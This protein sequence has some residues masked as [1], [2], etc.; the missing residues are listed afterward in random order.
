MSRL[1]L[2]LLLACTALGDVTIELPPNVYPM[3]LAV[4][5]DGTV[6]YAG[7][8]SEIGRVL[9]NGQLERLEGSTYVIGPMLALSDGAMVV[10]TW[11]GITRVD[12][13]MN[14]S[15]IDLSQTHTRVVDMVL[16]ADGAVWFIAAGEGPSFLGRI[17]ADGTIARFPL[18]IRP[19]AMAL[20]PDGSFTIVDDRGIIHRTTPNGAVELIG[21]FGYC[22]TN[23][24]KVTPDGTVWFEC[25][26]LKP[27][28]G[29]IGQ[30]S[31]SYASTIGPDGKV[32]IAPLTNSIR[33]LHDDGSFREVP[34]EHP[35]EIPRSIASSDHAIWYGLRGAIRRFDP[36]TPIDSRLRTGDIVSIE[37]ERNCCWEGEHPV[38]AFHHRGTRPFVRRIGDELPE[39]GGIYAFSGERILFERT[40][41]TWGNVDTPLAIILDG[42]GLPHESIAGRPDTRGT[43]LVVDRYGAIHLL[44]HA[45]SGPGDWLVTTDAG[46]APLRDVPVPINTDLLGGIDLAGD[47]CTLFYAVS[48]GSPGQVGRFDLCTGGQLS[49]FLTGLPENPQDLRILP[50]GGLVVVF[51]TRLVRYDSAGSVVREFATTAAEPFRSVA[52][53]P[54]IRFVWIG[55]LDLRRMNLATGEIV[56]HLPVYGTPWKL[57]IVGEPRAARRPARRRASRSPGL[58]DQ[59]SPQP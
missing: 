29:F 37:W 38:L 31:S 1:P 24:V 46:G 14:R 42:E 32:W 25:G 2:L 50:D 6:W 13:H 58:S 35:H 5:E 48:Y 57:S 43:G 54:D 21:N 12:R 16:G 41:R 23:W 59:A 47:Q 10:G 15:L 49:P 45:V 52:L 30:D 44:R 51:P 3:A 4:A 11:S 19:R 28:G 33:A 27:G 8:F 40:D 26:L 22:P 56:E 36:D 9:P 18:T 34:F 53:D 20:A 7:E 39:D 55:T 17:N